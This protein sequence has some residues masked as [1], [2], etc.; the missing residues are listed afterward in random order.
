MTTLISGGLFFRECL[1]IKEKVAIE[2]NGSNGLDT[3]FRQE[4]DQLEHPGLTAFMPTVGTPYGFG[5]GIEQISASYRSSQI[6]QQALY[7]PSG[8]LLGYIEL[9]N[10]PAYDRQILESVAWG[11]AVASV[12]AV[13]LTAAVGWLMSRRMSIPLLALTSTTTKM[14]DG[15]LSARADV[16]RPDEFGILAHAFNDMAQQIEETVVTLRCFVADAAHELYTPLTALRTNLELAMTADKGRH[17]L[18]ERAQAQVRRLETLTSDLLD[19]SHLESNTNRTEFASVELSKLLQKSCEPYASQAEQSGLFFSLQG[20]NNI[21]IVQGHTDQIHRAI[22]NLLDNTLKFTSSEGIITVG[23]RSS[24]DTEWAEI[25]VDDNGIGIPDD[26]L[27]QLFNRFHRGRNAAAYL[28]SG[29]GLAIV[30]VIV[31]NHQGQV[32]VENTK[33]N[34]RFIIRL[35][36]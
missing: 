20:P 32:M 4:I 8:K 19:L 3:L 2:I 26:E 6:V 17:H 24:P 21:I 25:W 12:I 31:D 10:G 36:L 29:L 13:L 27:P 11:W 14:A 16:D 9:S 34:T 33:T 5:L 28:G 22:N 23:L 1:T 7:N 35:P 30:K 15:E 18:I